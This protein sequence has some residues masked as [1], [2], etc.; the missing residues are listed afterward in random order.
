MAWQEE[1]ISGE[2]LRQTNPWHQYV[3]TAIWHESRPWAVIFEKRVK[4]MPD[5]SRKEP[6]QEGRLPPSTVL[7]QLRVQCPRRRPVR[8][9]G[10]SVQLCGK[11]AAGFCTPEVLTRLGGHFRIPHVPQGPYKAIV[12][13]V[14]RKMTPSTISG[15]VCRVCIEVPQ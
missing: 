8:E 13:G 7:G 14:E 5:R 2:S 11:G 9:A 10:H 4:T 15:P 6:G 1:S 3:L 12:D